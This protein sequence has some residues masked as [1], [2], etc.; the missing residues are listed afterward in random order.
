MGGGALYDMGIYC[1][2][3]ARYIFRAE[4]IE[5][6]AFSAYGH[7]A[8]FKQVEEMTSAVLRFPEGQLAQMTASQGAASVA[9]YRVIGTQGT[10]TCRARTAITRVTSTS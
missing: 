3:A 6:L 4:P 2:N 7:D 5:V 8:R 9:E 10:S 1:I